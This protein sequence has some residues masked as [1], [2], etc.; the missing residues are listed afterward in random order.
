[1][2][3][4]RLSI[5]KLKFIASLIAI[6]VL[7][8][9][10]IN[11]FVSGN[12]SVITKVVTGVEVIEKAEEP[13]I[14]ET[15]TVYMLVNELHVDDDRSLDG[16]E[17][18]LTAKTEGLTVSAYN[19]ENDEEISPN[20]DGNIVVPEKGIKVKVE[21]IRKNNSYEVEIEN[22]KVGEDYV[23]TFKKALIEI[24]ATNENTIEGYVKTITK[25]VDGEEETTNGSQEKTA[26]FMYEDESNK[27]KIKG[28]GEV[29]IYYIKSANID[30]LTEEEI[31]SKTEEDWTLYDEEEGIVAE[32]NCIIYA[33]SK[34]KTGE[35][36]EISEITV[37]NIDKIAPEIEVTPS[38]IEAEDETEV[39]VAI[40]ENGNKLYG[41][42]GIVAY[43]MTEE[44]VEPSEYTEI[45][46]TNEIETQIEEISKNGTYYL[47]AKD[48]AGN[49]SHTEF[50]VTNIK[51]KIV[52]IILESPVSNLI[53]TE[54]ESLNELMA[55]LEE[56]ELTKSS[57]KTVVQIVNDIKNES[58]Q[59]NNKNVEIDLNGYSISCKSTTKETL[60]I[61]NSNVLVVDNKY[62]IS[63]KIENTELAT[64]LESKYTTKVIEEV[65]QNGKI[66]SEKYNAVDI[67]SDATFTLGED[68]RNVSILTPIIDAAEVGVKNN[69]GTFN[70][71]DGILKGRS[72]SDGTTVIEGEITNKAITD[73]PTAYDPST[74]LIEGEERFRTILARV[75]GVEAVIGRTRYTTLEEAIAAA[76]NVK[77]TPETQVQIDIV[78]DINKS[79]SVE[80]DNTKNIKLN[81][82][83]YTITNSVSDYVFKNSGKMEVVD[84]ST[85]E[86]I[87]ID[88]ADAVMSSDTQY[89]FDYDGTTLKSNNQNINS[90]IA[91]S[92]FEIDLRDRK[93]EYTVVVNAEV[94]SESGYDKGY[95]AVTTSTDNAS[96]STKFINNISGVVSAT[97]YTTVLQPGS[98]YYLHVGYSKDNSKG[99]NADTFTI[100]S[101]KVLAGEPLGNIMSST[102]NV[103]KNNDG[104]KL[105]LTSGTI[106]QDY[107]GSSNSY[108]F[109]ITN[110]GDLTV[111]GGNIKAT[112]SYVAL[113]GNID[114]GTVEMN[115]GKITSTSS[116]Y[117]IWHN[118][119]QTVAL[120]EGN[121]EFSS[122]TGIYNNNIGKIEMNGGSI[123]CI[124]SGTGIY[125]NNTGRVEVNG[126]DITGRH[127]GIYNNKAGTIK[128]TEGN[129]VSYVDTT[130]DNDN[131]G[132]IVEIY[133]GTIKCN[134]DIRE[135]I[136]SIGTLK[137]FDGDIISSG[138]GVQC[139]QKGSI[140][141]TGGNI[142]S[143]GT[144]IDNYGTGTATIK[145]GNVASDSYG[146]YNENV[147]KIILSGGT[148]TTSRGTYGILNSGNGSIEMTGGTI[149]ANTYSGICN[150]NAGTVIVTNGTINST[151]SNG[152][153]NLKSGTI[154]IGEKDGTVKE[155]LMISAG[156]KGIYNKEIN[157]TVY[158]YDGIIKGE[159]EAIS[160]VI[161]A[162]E[163][164][165]DILLSNDET[166]EIARL[167]NNNKIAYVGENSTI[168]YD[169]LESAIEACGVEGKITL[170]KNIVLATNQE[171]SIPN[172]TKI[173]L[174]LNGKEIKKHS[175]ENLIINNGELKITDL[176]ENADGKI[177]G[178][179]KNIIINEEDKTLNI[180]NGT[181]ELKQE[182]SDS[183]NY[184]STITSNGTMNIA[185]GNINTTTTYSYA[186]NNSGNLEMTGGS[187]NT[188]GK[189]GYGINNIDTGTTTFTSTGSITTNAE[190]GYGIYNSDE[191]K[192]EMTG[193]SITTKGSRG[194]GIVSNSTEKIEISNGEITT[195]GLHAYALSNIGTG[196]IEMSGGTVVTTG[197]TGAGILNDVSGEAILSG[198]SITTKGKNGYG[199]YNYSDGTI[200][201]TG[202][203]ITT[204]KL[205]GYGIYNYNNGSIEMTGGTITTTTGSGIYI[206]NSAGKATVTGGN[207]NATEATGIYSK[208]SITLGTKDGN[209]QLVPTVGGTTGVQ[210]A[211]G[212][213]KFY[214]GIIKGRTNQSISGTITEI[215]DG[216]SK[217]TYQNGES[218]RYDIGAGKEVSVLETSSVALVESTGEIP[219]PTLRSAVE[220]AEATDIITLTNNITITEVESTIETSKN[221]TLDLNGKTI[222]A[223]NTFPITN[224]GTLTILDGT[225][226]KNG[227]IL[228]QRLGTS[229]ES[230]CCIINN[231]TLNIESGKVETNKEYSNGINNAGTLNLTG[232]NITTNSSNGHG[233]NN[234][235]EGSVNISGGTI[236]TTSGHG[237]NSS[238]LG[239]ITLSESGS[240]ITNNTSY[241]AI[242]NTNNGNVKILGGSISAKKVGIN[243]INIGK[244]EMTGG[245]ITTTEY[246]TY[247]I[248]NTNSGRVEMTGGTIT[249]S[250]D[251]S[252][253]IRNTS[254]G[255]VEVSGTSIIAANGYMRS[256]IVNTST[257][258]VTIKGDSN[259][260]GSYGVK[261]K[262]TTI[263]QGGTITATNSIIYNESNGIVEISGGTLTSTGDNG[264]QNVETGSIT[265]TG[266]EITSNNGIGI[267]NLSTGTVT[268]GTKDGNVINS[269]VIT[270]GTY[271][272][273][274]QNKDG[275]LYYYDGTLKAKENVI[276]G[277]VNEIE[278]N[279]D[280]VLSYDETY[281][282]A[283]LGSTQAVAY[284]GNDETDTY[285]NLE[286]VITACGQEGKIT[287][288]KNIL[289]PTGKELNTNQ[290]TKIT[291]NLNGK[292]IRTHSY[293]TAITNKG[294]II[295]TDNSEDELGQ[296]VGYG[297][298]MI[299][300][301]E[302][303][304]FTIEKGKIQLR[305][306][307][308]T[309][310]DYLSCIT[311]NGT[312]N[313]NGGT[314]STTNRYS[315]AIKNK[316]TVNMNG[317][318]IIT[319][320]T[321]DSSSYSACA[322][323]IK[324]IDTGSANI[325]DGTITT[326]GK[327]STA[328][329]NSDSTGTIIFS[330][331]IVTTGNSGYGIYNT[332]TGDVTIEGGTI[333]GSG[334]YNTNGTVTVED[335]NIST[336]YNSNILDIQGGTITNVSTYKTAT[337]V[338]GTI[339]KTLTN[340][341]NSIA[342]IQNITINSTDTAISN[343][344]TMIILDGT[345]TGKTGIVNK[346]ALTIN[347]G[348]VTGT[349]GYGMDNS[350]T[351]T[352]KGGTVSSQTSSGIY[353][354]M[355]LTLGENDINVP[356][357]AKPEIIGKTYGVQNARTFNFYDGIIKGETS[358]ISGTVT[359]TPIINGTQDKYVVTY[360]N[361]S[362]TEA[363]LGIEANVENTIEL[364]GEYSATLAEAILR[365]SNKGTKTGTIKINNGFT[366]NSAVTIPENVNVT[367]ELRGNSIIYSETGTAIVNNGTLTIIDFEDI[368]ETSVDETS[369][370]SAQAGT[371]IENNGTLVIGQTG[372]NNTNSPVITGS[373]AI[374]GNTY[375]TNSGSVVSTGSGSTKTLNRIKANEKQYAN[376]EESGN[377][378]RVVLS[379]SPE[380][381]ASSK[382]PTWTKNNVTVTAEADVIPVLNLYSEDRATTAN[383]YV[384]YYKDGTKVD[385]DIE[386][387]TLTAEHVLTVDKSKINTTN[388]YVG[389]HF[390]KTIVDD[391]E[392][393]IPDTV[394]EETVIKVYYEEDTEEISYAVEYY[395]DNTKV[396]TDTE[397]AIVTLTGAHTLTVDKSKINT[398][399][400]YSGYH[401]VETD[402]ATIPD[403]I[404]NGGVIKVYYEED[405]EEIS[406]TVEYYK[407]N[408]KTDTDTETA[409][410]TLTAEHVLTVDKSKI[411]T[412]NK[413]S[414]YHF[415][416]TDP[417]TISDTIE[418]GGVIKVY[419]VEDTE[420]ISY[421]V[422]YYKDNTKADTDTET[423][424]VTLT[425][426]HVLTVDKSKINTTNKYVG[427]HFVKTMVDDV[428]REIPGTVDNGT[429][430]KVYYEENTE[431]ISYAVEY[432]K[433]G[434]KVDEDIETATVTLTGAHTLTVDKSKINT[435][436]KYSGY[437]F[438]ETDPATIPDT[439]ENGG[440]LKV[441]YEEDTEEISYAV[442]YY[443]DGAKADEDIETATV[444]LTGAH[445]LT[446]DKSKINTTNKYSG[447][448][449][450]ETDPATIPD[451]I[452]NG[453]VIK[454]YYEEDTEEISYT[455]EYYKDNTKADTDTETAT[456]TLTA[457]HVL[458]VDKSKINT[459]N[460]YV[461]FHFVKTMV[462][463]VEREIPGTVD[464]GTVIKVYYEEN[465][466]EISYAV[467]YYKD[468]NKVDEDIE[469]ATVT[470]TGAHTLTVDKS[471]INTTNKYSGYHFVG[472]NPATIPDTI[473]NGGVIKVYYEEDTE[474]ISYTVEYYKD[475]TKVDTDTETATVTLTGAHTLTVD[476]SKINTTNKYSGYHFV[477]TDPATIPDTIANGGVI[478]VY[479]EEDT[480][481]I[482]YT[483]EYYKDN[484]KVDTDTETATV[485]LTGAHTLTVDKSKINTTNKYSGYHFVGTNPAT[486]PDTIENGGV[487]KVYYEE[488]TEEISYT[489][490]YY[491]NNTKVDTD[492]ETATVTLTGAH[493][494]T[495]DKS[496]INTTNKY[497]GY[498]LDSTSTGVIPTTV[499]A[500]TV[501]KVYYVKDS[502]GYTVEYYYEGTKD[503]S[504]TEP[505]TAEYESVITEADI[506]IDSKNIEGYRFEKTENAP[507]TI[508][509]NVENNVIK[510]YFI[511][512]N[513]NTK[514]LS[515]TVEYY[516]E[517]TKVTTD[518][519]IERTTVQV[520]EPNTL[521]VDKTKI[522]TTNKY[523]GYKLDNET[524]G[525]IPNTVNNG[526][527]IKVYYVKD[528]FNYTVEYY[529]DGEKDES[530]TEIASALYENII[531]DTEVERKD[532]EGYQFIRIENTPLTISTIAANNVIKVYYTSK[533]T[534]TI[535]HIDKYTNEVKDT[536]VI[537]KLKGEEYR[538]EA[539]EYKGY[540]LEGEPTNAQGITRENVE[541][542][543]YYRK[544]VKIEVRY[545]DKET[546][547]DLLKKVVKEGHQGDNYEIEAQE[548][549]YFKLQVR[550]EKEE[551]IMEEDAVYEYYYEP[552]KFNLKV[553]NAITRVEKNGEESNINAKIAKTEI[554][555]KK[556]EE[557]E[558]KIELK[559]KV[560]ND[561]ELDGKA[562]LVQKI[563]SGFEMQ[564]EDNEGWTI[565]DKLALIQ[566]GEIKVGE[567]KEYKVVLTWLQGE[568]NIGIKDYV[569]YITNAENEA[570]RKEEST[571]DNENSSTMILSISTGK[572]KIRE[573]IVASIMLSIT[574]LLVVIIRRK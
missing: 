451:T 274:T 11:Y 158:Y 486:I 536:E 473:E 491:K 132:G 161:N 294:K 47:W 504:K 30:G 383:Y 79:A 557:T 408:T 526:D 60:V 465:T 43:A 37:N 422:E 304:T 257:G 428:E 530:K 494:L 209:V 93:V 510:V 327:W 430:I 288:L 215:E 515:Y 400:K 241:T 419:Y 388:K 263:I 553:V 22:A 368:T 185:G 328:I 94:S 292:R 339:L 448:H 154:T 155:T 193:G 23:S 359:D 479:Y 180:E 206:N 139:R 475:N 126:G 98:I 165:K 235:N 272:L 162:I 431:E 357:I 57:L 307:E 271:A 242:N 148:V 68:D 150:S 35:Y 95:A 520:L 82:N 183:N 563:P 524:T 229:E 251:S 234:T 224:N 298:N 511:I 91:D 200:K 45:E 259:I 142:T 521:T 457:E 459:T 395:K 2:K 423:A 396:D 92:Y 535:K 131:T 468:G 26:V 551:G 323:G 466:E 25:V 105:T 171:K 53:G 143:S 353:N 441:Y 543:Y 362:G 360:T 89:G 552:L 34:Y 345:I 110:S 80:V 54:Y 300:N 4:R 523:L 478:K 130:I 61:K 347:T 348:T 182:N 377:G 136:Y 358:A 225:E 566:I 217:E 559:I 6:L 264:I 69:G 567:T 506:E 549:K 111:N 173:T 210:N 112:K 21:G 117:G 295:V 514:T 467:E 560:T 540:D 13:E 42:S 477:G 371:A 113:I 275:K 140:E 485:T 211:N 309:S 413:Y 205:Y 250:G 52:A 67:A 17:L 542:K 160:G 398:T 315:Y 537:Q 207:I 109:G 195:N 10:V 380:M 299:L 176:S 354:T 44:E 394:N 231:G 170:L 397:T 558:M 538:T 262:G 364:D 369:T 16:A 403:T 125:N 554:H 342:N 49:V 187:I 424:T 416:E 483:V 286:S 219:Y 230:S 519:Q 75:S 135:S 163:D 320:N 356:N 253:G 432:Y 63:E 221:L 492:T 355:T 14:A 312:L 108:K 516:K 427:F 496:K 247:G 167:G 546:G 226:E 152:L 456:V 213:F 66:C 194:F 261:N 118:N 81:L 280:V 550:P 51:H 439:I 55:T 168:T 539:K 191:S 565:D 317:G 301:E 513:E 341:S 9:I 547:K 38:T 267:N 297:R 7:T 393:E 269:P 70:Y 489:V 293:E 252:S 527:V 509:T 149:N 238:S 212:T 333:T 425:A 389:F 544:Q 104:A 116:A 290:N 120:N 129:I 572:E 484:T 569:T 243:N 175:L 19:V 285:D 303:K 204:S 239:D 387:A 266:G 277:I 518:T 462:D 370:I 500:G 255:D 302:G 548:I 147:G 5:L 99:E 169:S 326:Y 214:D 532:E 97:D 58:T 340:G 435:T 382:L 281:E 48:K 65:Q 270:S 481:E 531:E 166:Y 410:V 114:N 346:G 246:N 203:S 351:A 361:E 392:G 438:V 495:V 338:D 352:V 216:Y 453:G 442:E 426:E 233:I 39:E 316:G 325:I 237:I 87:E 336:I 122:G 561:G 31:A 156:D 59:I 384:E 512:D 106:I 306:V 15:H 404:E 198:G 289:L 390:V 386:T 134:T 461:G 102:A 1:M 141:M 378:E 174:N 283:T 407:D 73:T 178:Y 533:Y 287:L 236:K 32:N 227:K 502:F 447:Y 83:G 101:I 381:Q 469:T 545:I 177:W 366:L 437:H 375:T 88:M 276:I 85:E 86:D 282:I 522:N 28:N 331:N 27:I 64:E 318:N 121:I 450:V 474:E 240:I 330:G 319:E 137:I 498:K 363:I 74:T 445:T 284:V 444:T 308:G 571:E 434:N 497:V 399:N 556:L 471:K 41:K 296:I 208:G 78:T 291:L 455:V 472:T 405:T 254:T 446:V 458:T 391:V 401:F 72:T 107:G 324:N 417:A 190:R 460:K 487:I 376:E 525:I 534:I 476:K 248:N 429:V 507:L 196:T 138:K 470:L 144:G 541:V 159:N 463:D 529:Y 33:K 501:I 128:I 249:V 332:S 562:T 36:S 181:I 350:G 186:V 197:D 321:T 568:E 490:E 62:V 337:I 189:Y 570:G 245:S 96:G 508:S 421:T 50:E 517:G 157:G 314:I 260:S 273:R 146:I 119:A 503:E 420:E 56:N 184:I 305:L 202:G 256:G 374:T 505:G 349:N 164:N 222:T 279:K 555:K 418:N 133:G 40:T 311:N 76:N 488:D 329:D 454:V 499:E 573:Y 3:D 124:S 127:S 20:E 84:N 18:K 436:N 232:G 379:N 493:T 574:V 528:S 334:V 145:G 172:N 258:T 188:T 313:I 406:Y 372:T 343:S 223:G 365:V 199:I 179:G 201:M 103:I 367:L 90:S 268:I 8:G 151:I 385:E 115:G 433:D 322:I 123:S 415:V 449:F 46:A 411:N 192:T 278:E 220:A 153:E 440:V 344:G 71:Y 29:K 443:K 265:I 452:E 244:V 12:E 310:S 228:S 77:G 482:S 402:P 335:G 480:E 414:G 218:D 564:E 373:T 409:T 412:T 464:N 100:N 24:D